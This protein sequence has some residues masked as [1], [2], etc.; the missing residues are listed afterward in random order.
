VIHVVFFFQK[1]F[2]RFWCRIRGCFFGVCGRRERERAREWCCWR[3]KEGRK[4]GRKVAEGILS[5]AVFLG[6]VR[7]GEEESGRELKKGMD[8][9]QREELER[10]MFF[11]Q[12]REKAAAD[13]ARSPNDPD[14]SVYMCVFFLLLLFVGQRERVNY[15]WR[16]KASLEREREREREKTWN[17]VLGSGWF[18][19]FFFL[20]WLWILC[21]GIAKT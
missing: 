2:E 1:K 13:Y 18:F 20:L 16:N 8:I 5:F 21:P 14:V 12:T 9:M 10:L 11:E 6:L 3:R 17:E 19:L 7:G 4:E 15:S